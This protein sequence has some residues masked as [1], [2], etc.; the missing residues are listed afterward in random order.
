LGWTSNEYQHSSKPWTLHA[1]SM[2]LHKNMQLLYF[3]IFTLIS[4][5]CSPTKTG[6]TKKRIV[7]NENYK[8]IYSIQVP[9]GDTG[10]SKIFGGHGQ[11]FSIQYPDNSF[12]YYSDDNYVA[13]PNYFE[14]YKSINYVVPVGGP[15]ADTTIDGQQK[16]ENI[17][18]KSFI[19]IIISDIKTFP[20]IRSHCLTNHWRLLREKDSRHVTVGLLLCWQ[21]NKFSSFYS[22]S[23]AVSADGFLLNFCS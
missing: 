9:K 5:A 10:V 8:H 4:F 7:M 2:T 19:K 6:L 21:T 13:T 3:L 11:S 20:K 16:T 23:A 22:L 1:S 12:I 15:Q 17:G 18:K 14:N